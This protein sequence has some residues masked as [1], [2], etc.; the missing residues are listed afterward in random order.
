M[1]TKKQPSPTAT[2]EPGPIDLDEFLDEMSLPSASENTSPTKSAS[3]A[4]SSRHARMGKRRIPIVDLTPH[5]FLLCQTQRPRAKDV[6]KA[7]QKPKAPR[8]NLCCCGCGRLVLWLLAAPTWV[9]FV[10]FG[11]FVWMVCSLVFVA[12]HYGIDWKELSRQKNSAVPTRSPVVYYNNDFPS[13]DWQQRLSGTM[14]AASP[15]SLRTTPSSSPSSSPTMKRVNSGGVPDAPTSME[16]SVVIRDT[17]TDEPRT[18]V[19][20][21]QS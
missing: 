14:P 21:T 4:S 3:S 7:Q 6:F 1:S 20:T 8:K 17:A 18:L 11:A 16:P 12:V 9:Q 15:P 10:G 19:P 2:Y 5:T 13:S